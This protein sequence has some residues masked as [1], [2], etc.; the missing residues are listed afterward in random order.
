MARPRLDAAAT[1][2]DLRLL[3]RRRTPR[4]VFDYVDGGA[5]DEISLRR[6]RAAYDRV[7]FQPVALRDVA[8]VQPAA[9]VLGEPSALPIVLAPTGFTRM[10][11]H[12]GEPAVARVA[13]AFGIPYTLSTL[14]TTSPAALARAAPGTRRWFQLYL[15]RDRERTADLIAQVAGAGYDTIMVTVDTPVGGRRLR[16]VRNRMTIP[17]APRRLSDLR[18]L[19]WWYHARVGPQ[20]QFA[21]LSRWQGT[22]AALADTMF[23]PGVT[24]DDLRW[25][26]DRWPGRMLVKGVLSAAGATT[27]VEC[28]ADGVVVS[29]HG[30]RQLDRSPV[31]LEVLPSVVA[32]VGDRAA[33]LVDGG[34]RSGADV[35]AAVCLGASAVLVGR[36]YLYGLMAGGEPGVRRSLEILSGDVTHTMRLLGANDV[37]DLGAERVRL[38]A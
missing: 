24:V 22:A 7:E 18:R 37:K 31:P 5:G 30:G 29:N 23:D 9:T 12:H 6:D 38:R 1:V 11:H 2:A 26:R 8:Q 33:V 4:A 21:A 20:W 14:G 16:D 35:V 27:A 13:G 34:V 19:P 25:V 32:A 10:M 3:A 28:G 15:W 17:P 36:A